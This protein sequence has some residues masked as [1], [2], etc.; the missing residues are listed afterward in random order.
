ML[1]ASLGWPGLFSKKVAFNG[2]GMKESEIRPFD[3][4]NEYL[5]LLQRDAKVFFDDRS[6]FV[7]FD[8]LACGSSGSKFEFE[9]NGFQYCSCQQC[10]TLFVNPRPS[11]NDL[12]RFYKDSPSA[13]FWI[14]Q[15][16][17]PV[18]EVRREKIFRPRAEFVCATLPQYREGVVGDIGA[19]FGL[20]L[21]ELAN[22]WPKAKLVAIEPSEEQAT[23]CRNKG[24]E[25][26][27]AALEEV[28]GL[29]ERFDL[30]TAF[31]L[32]EHL[33]DPCRFLTS[34]HR[35]LKPGGYFLLTTLNGQG[36]DIQVLWEKSKSLSPP[37]HLN[38]FNPYSISLLLERC[39][40]TVIDV[41]TPGEL[42]WD[43]VEGMIKNEKLG[44][45]RFWK[46][47]AYNGSEKS[48]E[49][50]QQWIKA[51]NLSSHM[52]VIAKKKI[53]EIK[54]ESRNVSF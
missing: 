39:G 12:L 3:K 54:Q 30:M 19:G 14:N 20:F 16:F 51:N 45:E 41:S 2:A 40:F 25:V 48:K 42:D 46:F 9:K 53:S 28:K 11:L 36:F 7:S 13:S 18:A 1:S 49:E 27:C 38:F 37:Q 8:C 52:R 50:F 29:K 10:L 21:E 32:F 44:L 5:K 23:L 35:L 31:E 34:V 22:I 33:F 6:S 15:F 26:Q 43:I 24:L 17:K 4:L 47:L